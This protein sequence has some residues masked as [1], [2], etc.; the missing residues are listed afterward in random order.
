MARWAEHCGLTRMMTLTLDPKKIE[1][2][3]FDWIQETW[4]KFREYLRREYGTMTFIGVVELQRNGNPHLHVLVSRYIP[5]SWISE[6]WSA[7]GGGRIVDIRQVDIHRVRAYLAKYL[8][9]AW[10]QM[11]IPKGKRRF[12]TSRDIHLWQDPENAETKTDV[13]TILRLIA[14][15]EG[16][17][18]VYGV[19]KPKLWENAP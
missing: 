10:E 13:W 18:C 7:L 17:K 15:V 9:K 3:A 1:G 16:E 5:Q 12:R 8:N 4:R 14:Y 19:E 11:E 2:S 6:Q